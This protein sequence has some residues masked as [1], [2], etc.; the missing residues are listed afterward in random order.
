MI[1]VV[2]TLILFYL[3]GNET[4]CADNER[5]PNG[6]SPGCTS[7]TVW[8]SNFISKKIGRLNVTFFE[9][10]KPEWINPYNIWIPMT[11]LFQRLDDVFKFAGRYMI[12]KFPLF[13]WNE[14][15]LEKKW[16]KSNLIRNVEVLKL[17]WLTKFTIISFWL[18]SF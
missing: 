8:F 2:G 6:F 9:Y 3:L 17:K 15:I 4:R 16:K 12:S 11:M 5:S 7:M 13:V 14:R 1:V 18:L 10:E